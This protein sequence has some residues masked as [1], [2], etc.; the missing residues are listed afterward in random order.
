MARHVRRAD[1]QAWA[2]IDS[3]FTNIRET[4]LF[5]LGAA[6]IM[7]FQFFA[8]VTRIRIR[9]DPFGFGKSLFTFRRANV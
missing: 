7:G 5:W 9:R 2:P 3:F 8:V 6:D 1:N 4:L